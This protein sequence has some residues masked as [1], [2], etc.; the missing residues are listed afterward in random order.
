M[1]FNGFRTDAAV[2]REPLEAIAPMAIEAALEAERM[3]LKSEARRRQMIELDLQQARYEA[4]R[5]ERRYAA[6]DPDNRLIAAQL[7]KSW[8]AT[9]RRME[10]CEAR[11]SEVQRLRRCCEERIRA[12]E[13][14]ERTHCHEPRLSKPI[15]R[16]RETVS[17][18]GPWG[19]R[20]ERNLGSALTT[21]AGKRVAEQP[22]NRPLR[23]SMHK[24]FVRSWTR[25]SEPG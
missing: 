11:L 6:C 16:Y 20:I 13:Q 7:E 24:P 9:L 19:R 1:S 18:A 15:M 14:L 4:S 2:I 22:S 8:A 3:Q 5:A 25:M 23:I 21:S 17:L 10:S 12:R